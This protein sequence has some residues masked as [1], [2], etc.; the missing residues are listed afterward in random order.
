M[1]KQELSAWIAHKVMRWKVRY[2]YFWYD[3]EMPMVPRIR[4]SPVSDLNQAFEALKE[5]GIGWIMYGS[6]DVMLIP[7]QPPDVQKNHDGT[8]SG[9]AMAICQAIYEARTGQKCEVEK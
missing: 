2:N 4:Y 1:T 7:D 6:G 9:I 3:G 8:T 5:S